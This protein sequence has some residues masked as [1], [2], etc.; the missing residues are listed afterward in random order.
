MGAGVRKD[1]EITVEINLVVR[2]YYHRPFIQPAHFIP[3]KN[4]N[5]QNKL[6]FYL[7]DDEKALKRR[8]VQT[9]STWISIL[10]GKEPNKMAISLM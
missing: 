1:Y 8:N 5:R 2:W 3:G 7:K 10:L 4:I 6:I 9:L